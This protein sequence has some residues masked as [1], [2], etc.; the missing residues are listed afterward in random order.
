VRRVRAAVVLQNGDGAVAVIRRRRGDDTWYLLPGGGVDDGESDEEAAAREALEELGVE[1]ETGA[2]LATVRFWRD[3]VESVQRHFAAT[4]SAGTFGTGT[5]P[6]L[7]SDAATPQG[8]YEPM[9]MELGELGSL[10]AR[11]AALFTALAS[12]GLE[13]LARCPLDLVERRV[14]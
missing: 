9:W 11:P 12:R 13:A 8:S 5:G 4:I 6:E 3:G 1:V 14:S 10:D 2:L 7:S